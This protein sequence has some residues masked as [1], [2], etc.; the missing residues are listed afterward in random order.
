MSTVLDR[1]VQRNPLLGFGPRAHHTGIVLPGEA[2][3]PT[4]ARRRPRD[5][6]APRVHLGHAGR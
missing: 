6:D 4:R 1:L 5:V 3:A 2:P